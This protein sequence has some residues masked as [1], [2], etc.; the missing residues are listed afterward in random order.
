MAS[1]KPEPCHH[2]KSNGVRCGSPALRNERLC[3][4]HRAWRPITLFPSKYMLPVLEDAS[5]IQLAIT[6]VIAMTLDQI[7]EPKMATTV[8]YA[9]QIAS[10]NLH[11]MDLETPK[12]EDV[13]VDPDREALAEAI[14]DPQQ[15]NWHIYQRNDQPDEASTTPKKPV[16]SDLPPGT[17]QACAETSRQGRGIAPSPHLPLQTYSLLTTLRQN[18]TNSYIL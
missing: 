17:I 6:R 10:C 15:P 7:I 8:L 2:I 9:L 1:K 3:Y 4:F 11:R 5:S 16:Q 18:H 12:P 14:F 13:A